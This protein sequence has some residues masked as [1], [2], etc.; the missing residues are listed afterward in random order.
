MNKHVTTVHEKKNQFKCE[1]CDYSCSLKG[2]VEKILKGN[3]DWIPSPSPSV[4]IMG[5]KVFL[6]GRQNIAGHCQQSF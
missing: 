5:T 3:L 4:K 1:M 2:K 6:M